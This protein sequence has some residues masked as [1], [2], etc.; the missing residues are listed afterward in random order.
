MGERVVAELEPL[1]VEVANDIGVARDL[2]PDDEE[3]GRDVK[4][5]QRGRDLRGP[6]RIGPV[7]EGERNPPARR[8][9]SRLQLAVD[10]AEQRALTGKGTGAIN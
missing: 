7:V 9:L 5:A 1:T 6:P 10:V 2:A 8:L 3:R 4:R